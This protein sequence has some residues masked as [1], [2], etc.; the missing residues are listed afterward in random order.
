M[1]TK[2]PEAKLHEVDV[3]EERVTELVS[4]QIQ[5]LLAD[6]DNI[7]TMILVI[8]TKDGYEDGA[9]IGDAKALHNMSVRIGH[10]T[11]QA[12]AQIKEMEESGETSRNISTEAPSQH[13]H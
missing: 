4:E 12:F 7:A 5:K 8:Q 6:P 9:M 10:V 1:S 11:E 13:L 3:D 2:M